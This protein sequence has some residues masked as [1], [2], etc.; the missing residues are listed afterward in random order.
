MRELEVVVEFVGIGEVVGIA[1]IEGFAIGFVA[2]LKQLSFDSGAK[3]SEEEE[4][5]AAA[6]AAA[7]A[8]GGFDC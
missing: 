3:Y 1:A 7:D 5:E 4:E 6:A 2:N 8:D